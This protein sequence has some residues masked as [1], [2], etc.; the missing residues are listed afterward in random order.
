MEGREGNENVLREQLVYELYNIVT[1]QSL[2]TQLVEITYNDTES[3]DKIVRYGILIEDTDEMAK[4]LDGEVCEECYNIN[5]ELFQADNVQIYSMFQ[6]M[7]GNSDWCVA[8]VKNVKV[9]QME[10]DGS[11]VVIPYDFDFCGLV[12]AS[13]AVPDQTYNLTSVRQRAFRNVDMTAEQ[14]T[15]VTEHFQSKKTAIYAKIS[16]YE[17]L[18]KKSRKDIIGYMDSF[19][20]ALDQQ[21]F[22]ED[23]VAGRW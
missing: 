4:R 21:V 23:Q 2:R 5:P 16:G 20:E 18:S 22:M 11:F 1:D 15:M 3:K 17:F 9:L 14:V 7:I 6:Y 10:K 12:N 13:Y 19:Y 8:M